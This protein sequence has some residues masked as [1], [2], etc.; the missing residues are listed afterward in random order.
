MKIHSVGS[1]LGRRFIVLSVI[2]HLVSSLNSVCDLSV[3]DSSKLYNYSLASPTGKFPH[4]VLSEDGFYQVAVNE[5]VL[6]FQLCDRMIFNHDPPNCLDCKD[7]GGPTRCGLEC[8]ALVAND[9]EGY[10]VCTTIGHKSNIQIYVADKKNPDSGAIVKMSISDREIGEQV[11]N[12]SLSVSVL[13]DYRI[14]GPHYLEKSGTC[15]YA[16]VLRH[17]SGCAK[18]IHIHGKGWGWFGVLLVT[19]IC[20]LGGYMLAGTVYRYFVL[21]VHGID[22]IPNLEFWASLPHR[23][24]SSFTSLVRKIRGPSEG[25]RSSY[26]RVNF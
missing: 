24:Q 20:L 13:C 25:Y 6:W 26:S 22:A 5:T 3:R 16:A 1:F 19:S 14:Q 18:V 15:D 12:C 9:I 23:T 2:L 21:G 11:V 8:S 10:P 7:C 17:P 4:G